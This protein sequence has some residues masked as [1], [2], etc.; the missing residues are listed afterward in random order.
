MPGRWLA[1]AREDLDAAELL[2]QNG[3][4]AIA[5]FHC[6]QA[7]EKAL[8]AFLVHQGQI[9]PRI[10]DLGDLLNHCCS[11][12]AALRVF[13]SGCTTL[14]QFYMPTRYPDLATVATF[15]PPHQ[16]QAQRA[17]GYARD[18]LTDLENR[19]FPPQPSPTTT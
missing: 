11:F 17:L 14:T 1:F 5:C 8:K 3:R 13:Q 12:D 18:I 15:T 2:I 10:H 16:A 4:Y 19:I 7:A 9:P 6:Q